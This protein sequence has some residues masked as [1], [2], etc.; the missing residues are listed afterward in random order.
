VTV[1]DSPNGNIRPGEP[2]CART[3]GSIHADNPLESGPSISI[4]NSTLSAYRTFHG[5]M[6]ALGAAWIVIG[7]CSCGLVAIALPGNGNFD[8]RFRIGAQLLMLLGGIQIICVPF[9]VFTCLKKMWALRC[10]LALSYV[11]LFSPLL[12]LAISVALGTIEVLCV[13]FPSVFA[14]LI[15]FVLILQAHRVIAHRNQLNE[16]GIR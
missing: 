10:G 15:Y 6:L 8:H 2:P 14:S 5:Q 16:D 4:S 9:G 1:P 3:H 11:L 7:L 12:F 13:A